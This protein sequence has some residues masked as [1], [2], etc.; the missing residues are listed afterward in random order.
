MRG[1]GDRMP[2]TRMEST[3]LGERRPRDT[4]WWIDFPL[5]PGSVTLPLG[6]GENIVQVV[7]GRGRRYR[8]RWNRRV[9]S[10][11]SEAKRITSLPQERVDLRRSAFPILCRVPDLEHQLRACNT[12][13][14]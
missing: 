14:T 9:I 11:V 12:W 10:P 4:T 3:R 6:K 1:V 2:F 5:C 13:P 8:R 7:G